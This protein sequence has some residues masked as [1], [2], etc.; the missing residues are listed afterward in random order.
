[1]FVFLFGSGTK[2][3]AKEAKPEKKSK[4]RRTE[5]KSRKIKIGIPEKD[6]SGRRTGKSF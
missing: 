2:S 3:R 4:K 5:V 6:A 1:M